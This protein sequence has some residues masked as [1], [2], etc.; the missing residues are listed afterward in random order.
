M[1][2][3]NVIGPQVRRLRDSLGWTQETLAA[4]CNLQGWDLSRGTLAKIEAQVRCVT[5]AELY[6]LA[7]ALQVQL[8]AL[9]PH[10]KQTIIEVAGRVRDSR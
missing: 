4:K 5:D 6:V 10:Q 9:F 7:A 2:R 1:S 3:Q 8:V